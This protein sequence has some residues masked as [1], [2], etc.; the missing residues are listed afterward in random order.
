[1]IQRSVLRWGFLACVLQLLPPPLFK[2]NQMFT[3][4]ELKAIYERAQDDETKVENPIW[5]R[6]FQRLQDAAMFMDHIML[7]N[8]LLDLENSKI[9]L[10]DPPALEE[11]D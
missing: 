11:D 1:M 3:R 7:A 5:K 10:A 6:G 2:E 8:E 4:L 9:K